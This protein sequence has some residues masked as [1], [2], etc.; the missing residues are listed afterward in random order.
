MA[1]ADDY[2]LHLGETFEVPYSHDQYTKYY[3]RPGSYPVIFRVRAEDN[4]KRYRLDDWSILFS[5][6]PLDDI[7]RLASNHSLPTADKNLFRVWGSTE[8]SYI[9]FNHEYDHRNDE[10]VSILSVSEALPV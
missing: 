3:L 5:E 6:G 7:Q 10:T 1:C 2:E 4:L 9:Q 8:E